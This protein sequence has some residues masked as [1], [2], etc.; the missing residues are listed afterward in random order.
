MKRSILLSLLI[1]GAV[2]AMVG[3]ASFSAFTDQESASGT[4]TAGTVQVGLTPTGSGSLTWTGTGCPGPIG[5]GDTCTSTVDVDYTG[6]LAA[7]MD[8]VLTDNDAAGCFNV[9]GTWTADD[10]TPTGAALDQTGV[11]AEDGTVSVSVQLAPSAPNS[12][13]GASVDV[14]LTVTTTES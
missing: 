11:T 1:I 3:G 4:V 6:N 14:T 10:G 7:T 5:T 13:Q 12:C 2:A 9:S 8:L